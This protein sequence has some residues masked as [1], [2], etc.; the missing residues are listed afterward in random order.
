MTFRYR[1]NDGMRD[2]ARELRRNMSE[3]EKKLWSRLRG[4]QVGGCKFRRQEPLEGYIVDF[5]CFEKRLVVEVDGREHAEQTAEDAERAAKLEAA[6]YRVVRFWN[7]DVVRNIDGVVAM[8][9]DAVGVP[10]NG[11]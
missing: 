1:S 9:M 4:H 5:V 3:V 10:V 8:I 11:V 7:N 2:R 6:G